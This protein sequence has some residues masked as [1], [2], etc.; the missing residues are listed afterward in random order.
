MASQSGELL[1][2]LLS[3]GR[4]DTR[5]DGRDAVADATDP[6]TAAAHVLT[7]QSVAAGFH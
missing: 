4:R 3:A 7:T 1:E 6:L 2:E 5:R